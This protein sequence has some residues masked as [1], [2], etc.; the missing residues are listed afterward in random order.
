MVEAP[1]PSPSHSGPPAAPTQE[2]PAEEAPWQRL[3]S[4]AP[5]TPVHLLQWRQAEWEMASPGPTGLKLVPKQNSGRSDP[6][7]IL[8]LNQGDGGWV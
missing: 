3:Q 1:V 7:N 4:L 8:V 6:P 5:L 2:T